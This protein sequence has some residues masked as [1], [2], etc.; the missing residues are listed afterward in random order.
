MESSE[1]RP[2][3]FFIILMAQYDRAVVPLSAVVK[4]YIPRLT[5]AKMLRKTLAGQVHLPITRIEGSQKSASGVHISDLADYI[6]ERRE[7][8][9]KECH[10][11]TGRS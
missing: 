11:L 1:I 10:Q 7:T 2:N 3:T 5:E 8:A 9:L 4:D 6:D